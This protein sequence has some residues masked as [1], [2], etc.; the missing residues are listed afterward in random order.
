M[1]RFGWKHTTSA[2]SDPLD[3]SCFQSQVSPLVFESCHKVEPLHTANLKKEAPT[4]WERV[5]L[6]YQWRIRAGG[7]RGIYPPP[8]QWSPHPDPPRRIPRS[9]PAYI[10]KLGAKPPRRGVVKFVLTIGRLTLCQSDQQILTSVTIVTSRK[11]DGLDPY[12]ELIG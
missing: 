8:P 4:L 5:A 10:R 6:T 12:R 3:T 7:G 2:N 9:A 1:R 11:W